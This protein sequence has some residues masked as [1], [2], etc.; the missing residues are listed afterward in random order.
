MSEPAQKIGPKPVAPPAPEASPATPTRTIRDVRKHRARRLVLKLSIAV[1]LPTL[2]ASV[3]YG[4]IDTPQYESAT[5]FTVQ[6]A[7]DAAAPD[8]GFL[9]GSASGSS[10]TPD[11]HIARTYIRSRDMLEILTE[12]HGFVE[13]YS[14]SDVDWLS[15]LAPDATL[16]DRYEYYLDQLSAEIDT[17]SGALEV[18]I[19]AFDP[20]KAKELSRA[21][22]GASEDMVNRMMTD[23]RQDRLELARREVDNAEERLTEVR[24]AVQKLRAERSEIDPRASAEA[25]LSVKSSLEAELAAARAELNSMRAALQPGAAQLVAQKQRVASLQGQIASQQRRLADGDEAGISGSIA[26]FEPLLGRKELAEQAYA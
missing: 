8:I 1:V 6:K 14:R 16:E 4:F 24:Q 11:V 15:R 9:L 26:E 22:L 12:H 3:Y 21:I 23:A 17:E 2:L 5:A 18:S 13:H 25:M 20:D 19:R 10:A 7:D